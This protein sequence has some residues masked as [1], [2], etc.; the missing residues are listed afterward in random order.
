MEA[1][2]DF[3]EFEGREGPTGIWDEKLGFLFLSKDAV[4]WP[5]RKEFTDP[6]SNING[7]CLSLWFKYEL[8]PIF[9]EFM[10]WPWLS[11][12]VF[13]TGFGLPPGLRGR[14]EYGDAVS[15]WLW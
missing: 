2:L 7:E 6:N 1:A 10:I 15:A 4:L 11:C 12:I 14:V 9:D 3:I 5:P 8:D 13:L